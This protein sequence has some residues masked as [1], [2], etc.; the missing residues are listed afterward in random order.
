MNTEEQQQLRDK[1]DNA[2]I[3]WAKK[4]KNHDRM[5]RTASKYIEVA[6]VNNWFA[7]NKEDIKSFRC[8][9][10]LLIWTLSAYS[11]DSAQEERLYDEL[12]EIA[13][14]IHPTE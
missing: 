10:A 11:L 5:R 14:D 1:A 6:S 2:A 3:K 9:E 8:H 7:V 12:M 13:N 4:G